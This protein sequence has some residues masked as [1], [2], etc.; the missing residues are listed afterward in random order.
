MGVSLQ[1]FRM[2]I[3]IFHGVQMNMTDQQKKSTKNIGKKSIMTT[4]VMFIL[5]LMLSS[6]TTITRNDRSSLSC[7]N[8]KVVDVP[9]KATSNRS[10]VVDHNFL[11]RYTFGNKQRTGLKLAHINMGNG[12]LSNKLP[13]LE[14]I[15]S[16]VKPHVIG[17]SESRIE[18]GHDLTEIALENYSFYMSNTYENINLNVSRL[19]VF[20]H[21]SVTTKVRHDLMS[22][23]FSS[24]WLEL[25][26][27]NQKKILLSNV[28]RDWQ[29]IH[30]ADNSSR[31]RTAQLSRWCSILQQWEKQLMRTKRLLSW[32]T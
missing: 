32:E 22:D 20:V 19:C 11:A 5:I 27:R 6:L 12:Y 9:T 16:E 13:E 26:L 29:Y 4:R 18:K 21:N 8:S 30:Q 10:F 24:I 7:S 2:T 15:I 3:G 25:G 17:I 23:S 14:L 28:Y 31:S 1:I